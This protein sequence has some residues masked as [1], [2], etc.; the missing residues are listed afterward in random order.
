MK[1][2]GWFDKMKSER[3]VLPGMNAEQSRK[4]TELYIG[5][6]DNLMMVA[7]KNEDSESLAEEAV[8]ETF[9]IACQKLEECLEHP[10]PQGWLVST[11]RNVIRNARR[12]RANGKRLIEQ[13]LMAQFREA[14]VSEDRLDL[15]ILYGKTADTEEFRLIFEMAVDGRS[16]KEMAESRGISVSACK[17]RVQR[18]K[19]ILQRKL[20]NDVTT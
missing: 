4:I 3:G 19:E 1:I 8:Q 17:K 18:A 20:G 15:N 2:R 6:Y 11:L 9:S 14:S 10:S 16:H 7:R 12:K 5:M 13:Y